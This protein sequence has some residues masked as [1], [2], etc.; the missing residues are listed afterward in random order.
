VLVRRFPDSG[1]LWRHQAPALAEAEFQVVVPD[2][3]GAL[4]SGRDVIPRRPDSLRVQAPTHM[5]IS[6]KIILM[7]RCRHHG[8]GGPVSCTGMEDYHVSLA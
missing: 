6:G 7:C 2:L 1:R 5:A 4:A 8:P 3:R